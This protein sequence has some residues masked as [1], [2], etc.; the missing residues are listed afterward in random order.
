MKTTTTAIQ[1]KQIKATI[2]RHLIALL[3]LLA[4]PVGFAF[5]TQ[6]QAAGPR[7]ADSVTPGELLAIRV[8]TARY[9]SIEAVQRNG[10]EAFLDCFE[11]T[12]VGGMG[13]HYVNFGIVDLTLDPLAPE[14]MV[15]EPTQNGRLKLGAVEYIVPIGPWDEQHS[16]R[17]SLFGQTFDRNDTLGVYTL[18]LWAWK[19]N[20]LGILSPWNPDVS[21]PH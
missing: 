13:F 3:A 18:H 10:Y 1:D 2:V 4:A 21:C 9:H 7:Q 12:G 6:A 17:P 5:T 14:G 8:A 19:F 16:E 11:Q 15:Y 20:R